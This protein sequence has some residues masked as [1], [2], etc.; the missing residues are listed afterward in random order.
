MS[1]DLAEDWCHIHLFAQAE[2]GVVSD[3]CRLRSLTPLCPQL[4]RVDRYEPSLSTNHC[5]G[6]VITSM[7]HLSVDTFANIA[8]FAHS[9]AFAAASSSPSVVRSDVSGDRQ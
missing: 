5:A 1:W 8:Y 2:E 3:V 7:R 6:Q 4:D 9:T